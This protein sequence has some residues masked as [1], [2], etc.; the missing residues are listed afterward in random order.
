MGEAAETY[1]VD[2]AL[3]SL[4]FGK[5]QTLVLIYS[6]VAYAAE[7]MEVMIL[8]FIGSAVQSK[9]NL[10][11]H[12][13]SLISSVVFAGMLVGAYSW[14]VISDNYGRRKGFLFTALVTSGVGFLS[15]FSP[16]YIALVILRFFVG[17]GLGGG[18][19]L[20]SWCL[21][22]V[23]APNRGAW[24]SAFSIF[25]SVGTILEAALAWAIMP[26]LG[27]R[28]LL[29]L[30]SLPSFLL[31]IFYAFTPESP[32]YLCMKGRKSEA[33]HILE[34]MAR[35]NKKALPTGELISD[36]K[37]EPD[38]LDANTDGS[39]A[40]HAGQ[41]RKIGTSFGED[42]AAKVKCVG[43][44]YKLL[45]PKLIRTTLLLWMGFFG[46]AFTYYGVILLTSGLS[47]GTSKCQS[48]SHS[49]SKEGT[50]LYKDVFITSLAELPGLLIAAVIVDRIGRKLSVAALLFV[51][52]GFLLPLIFHH[53]EL[54][55]TALLFG[56]RICITG[57]I[58]T[59]SIYAPEIYP[60]SVRSTGYGTANSFGKIGGIIC[61]IVAVG[62]VDD[63]HLL[64]AVLL[65]EGVI[66]LTGLA[67]VLFPFDTKGR[68]L[69]DSVESS[70]SPA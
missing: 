38:K 47:D 9:W 36:H 58:T 29:A 50:R 3:I 52:F 32:R 16:N 31:L 66:F 39:Q 57:S 17:V 24:M 15:T 14:G 11:P 20:F 41:V 68:D 49:S 19:V 44:L 69:K 1:T 28:W 35:M 43:S 67:V 63:C 10:S 33:L 26:T 5:F 61:P 65:F 45:S 6:G 54:T 4:G 64:A 51:T 27:W 8:S 48:S 56:A 13:K 55:T 18:P 60:T 30:S 2:D 59:L 46:N 62:L 7:A 21:E 23:P 53:K 34:I 70:V 40:A 42:V 12:E 37:A 22:F 25:W